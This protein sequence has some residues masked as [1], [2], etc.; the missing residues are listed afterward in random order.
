MARALLR[1]GVRITLAS[2]NVPEGIEG[3]RTVE[4][5]LKKRDRIRPSQDTLEQVAELVGAFDLIQERAEESGGLGVKLAQMTEKCL[6]LE[7]NTPLSGHANVFVRRLADWNLRRQARAATAIITQTPVSR[8]IIETY[9]QAPVYV[10]PNAAD[11]EVFSPEV[12]PAALPVKGARRPVVAFAG[13]LRP[14]HGVED[15]IAGGA[16]VLTA[17]REAFFLF[18]G[19]G[20]RLGE[21]RADAKQTLGEGNFH[22]TG[23]VA[24]AQV[25]A[26]LA[27]ADILVAPFSPQRDR[28]R[29]AHFE[30]YGMWWSPVKI[31]EYMAMGKPIVASAAGPVAEYISRAGITVP[32]G[33]VI[34]LA[35]AISRLLDDP[36]LATTLGGHARRKFLERHTWSHAATATLAAW[37]DVLE[38]RQRV[39]VTQ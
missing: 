33:D 31:F 24:P 13:S 22:F 2:A 21:L 18:V 39:S 9:S 32:P 6:I 11:P 14:W 8:H 1:L 29:K 5:R 30:K 4:V 34:G 37:N 15:L 23:A 3:I 28:V 12:A 38:G 17:H 35:H 16:H 7:I 10:V 36:E 27:A 19:G 25:P 20:T 26:Y